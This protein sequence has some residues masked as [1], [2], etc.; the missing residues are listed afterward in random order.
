MSDNLFHLEIITPEKVLISEDIDSIEAPGVDG[1]FQILAGH[2][3]FLTGLT[4]GPVIFHESG[5]RTL[6]SISGGF[7]EIQPRKTII[8]AH[9]AELSHEIDK[10]RAEEAQKRAQTRLE[11]IDKS[12]SDDID[13]ERAQAALY[14]AVNRLKVAEM[15]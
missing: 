15:K 5:K 8:L 12:Y 3:P 1:E 2:T 14:R 6:V 10:A 4:T 7:C 9:T 11:S 13:I